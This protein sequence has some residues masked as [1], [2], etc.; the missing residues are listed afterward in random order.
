MQFLYPNVLFLML[1]PILLLMFLIVTN[2]DKFQRYFSKESL[3]K[4]SIANKSMNKTT[5]NILL[6]ISLILMTIALARPVANERE[7][8]FKQNVASIVIAI[9]VSR[10]MLAADIYPNRLSFAKQKLLNLIELAKNSALAVILFGQDSFVLS[11]VTQDYNSLKILVENI[12]SGIN[13]SNGSNIYSTIEATKKLLKNYKSKNLLLLTDGGNNKDY[14]DEI[15]FAKQNGINIY[16]LAIGKKEPAPIKLEDG[17]F[18]T[19]SDG[20]IVTVSL[21]DGI[22]NLS[23]KTNG[24]YIEYSNTNED[25]K[26]ILADINRKSDKKELESKKYKTYTELFYYPLA[27]AVFTLL[28]ALF[29]LPKFKKKRGTTALVLLLSLNFI[30]QAKAF[31]FDFKNI[32]KA[33]GYYENRDYKNAITEYEKV[34]KTPEAKYNLGNAYYKNKQ[35]QKALRKYQEVETSNQELEH[36]KLH[37]LGNTYVKLNDLENAKKMYENSLNI[38]EDKDTRENL[39]RV[40]EALK[41]NQNTKNQENQNNSNNQNKKNQ[42]KKNKHQNNNNSQKNKNQNNN[43]EKDKKENKK[44]ENLNKEENANKKSEQ[45]ES[46]KNINRER[47]NK[48]KSDNNITQAQKTPQISEL[49]EKKWLEQIQKNRAPTI[50]KQVESKK[51]DNPSTP[52]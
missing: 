11:P 36:K 44:S 50:L 38:K 40:E 8:S 10:S 29:S 35:Y 6:F 31:E 23:L 27:F 13:F 48:N 19:N 7:Q 2:K 16:T 37:N 21:N 14:D 33:N 5:R 51:E 45:D 52:W 12:N 34:A 17:N 26:Q 4:L 25:I 9:D 43:N 1:L 42:D 41:R 47:K 30:E 49:E 3:A 20:S 22:K 18:L 46:K 24:G 39:K 32:E 15:E 28:F